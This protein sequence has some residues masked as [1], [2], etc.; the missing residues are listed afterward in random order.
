MK[1]SRLSGDVSDATV[2]IQVQN[3]NVWSHHTKRCCTKARHDEREVLISYFARQQ[4]GQT[5]TQPRRSEANRHHFERSS[6]NP[7]PQTRFF[8]SLSLSTIISFPMFALSASKTARLVAARVV[9]TTTTMSFSS[10]TTVANFKVA[11]L[12]ANGGIGQP[13]SMLLKLSPLVQELAL[14]DIVGTPGVAADLSHVRQ[15]Q[16]KTQELYNKEC[17][18]WGNRHPCGKMYLF[19]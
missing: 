14:Y 16:R 17:W 4:I 12:G 15:N 6:K 8:F 1:T 18:F 13:L 10:T 3:S 11:V 19:Y 2:S 7:Q 9:T 5:R